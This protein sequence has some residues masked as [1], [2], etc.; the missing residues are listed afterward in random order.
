MD[1][2]N[3][4]VTLSVN[5]TVQT[6]TSTSTVAVN[7]WT[8]LAVTFGTGG[9]GHLAGFSGV[10]GDRLFAEHGLA[11]CDGEQRVVQVHRVGRGD[12][13]NIDVRRVDEVLAGSEGVLDAEGRGV[14]G[15]GALVTTP[16]ASDPGAVGLGEGWH[17]AAN[18][19][20]AESQY[21]EA[22]GHWIS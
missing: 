16:Q 21:G 2:A 18:A 7:A 20:I 4:A 13:D 19:V 5:G 6:L 17:Q 22:Y 11:C 15:G 10:H 9:V 14:F 8:H 3:N 12:E 1:D